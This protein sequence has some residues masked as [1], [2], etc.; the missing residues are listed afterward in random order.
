MTQPKSRRHVHSRSIK[1]EAYARDDGLWDLEARLVDTK[2]RDF[3]LAT[4]LR[5]AG[6]PVHDM[7]L[8][9]TIDTRLNVIEA[10]ARSDRVPY[11]GHC[12]AI[13]PDYRKLVGL[14]LAKD[15]RRH[16]R[17][18]L[19]GVRGC[20]HLSELAGV[21]PSAAVQAFANEVYPTRDTAHPEHDSDERKP[22]QLDRCH[23][24]RTDGAAVATYY[25]RWTRAP[26]TLT[27]SEDAEHR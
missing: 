15:F 25:P 27:P 21:L 3:Q 18:R 2:A 5:V 10:G 22:F 19:G 20:T 6:D 4:G 8:W 9:V 16:V 13:G 23:A 12:E 26:E 11:P 7:S 17:E 24:L 14:N 1:V